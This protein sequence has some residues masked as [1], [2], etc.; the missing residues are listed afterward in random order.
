MSLCIIKVYIPSEVVG[1]AVVTSLVVAAAVVPPSNLPYNNN[2]RCI[3]V[4]VILIT[5]Q[6][7]RIIPR[8]AMKPT[9]K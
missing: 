1:T 8:Q 4:S 5:I 7:Y 3:N 6:V 9:L 2:N